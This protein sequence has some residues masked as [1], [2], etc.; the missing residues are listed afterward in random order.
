MCVVKICSA[1]STIKNKKESDAVPKNRKMKTKFGK[2]VWEAVTKVHFE[3]VFDMF[4]RMQDLT[5][6]MR[7]C[8]CCASD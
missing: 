2:T 3:F 4:K 7:Q 5:T 8:Q 6:T 1:E